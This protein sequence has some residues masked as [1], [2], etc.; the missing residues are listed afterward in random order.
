MYGSGV[1]K[2]GIAYRSGKQNVRADALSRNPIPTDTPEP[3]ALSAQI[4]E[5]YTN[6]ADITQLLDA[7]P[8]QESQSDFKVEQQKDPELNRLR[9]FLEYGA[10]PENEREVRGIAAQ[11]LNFTIIDDVLYYVDAKGGGRKRAAVPRHLQKLVLEDYHSGRMAGHFSGARLYTALSRQWW[12]RTMYRDA[13]DFSRSCGECATVAGVGRRYQ[14]PLHPIPVQHP[15]QII[16]VDIMELPVTE[17]GNRYVIVFQD[18]LTKW[19]LV[20]PAPDQK[21]IRLARLVAE[22]VLPLFGVPDALL[23]DRGKNLLAHVMQDV[24]QLLG[25]TKLNTTSY[26]PQC[27]GMVERMNWTLK[28]M[29]RKHVAKFGGQWDRYLPGVLWA[30]RNTPHESTKEKPSFLVWT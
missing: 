24:C 7:A 11:A 29:L 15:F 20:F 28:S 26:H 8:G 10:L 6:S 5:V 14:P 23:S 17:Q 30:Y 9:R 2:V 13:M 27:N 12:W 21:A 3:T 19:P 4:A 16:G 18:F 1:R 25:V 22:E